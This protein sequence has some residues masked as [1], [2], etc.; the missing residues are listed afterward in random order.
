MPCI[1]VI[2]EDLEQR[3]AWRRLFVRAGYTV[4]DARDSREGLHYC[5]THVIDLVLMALLRPL[6]QE[7]AT[8]RAFRTGAPAVRLLVLV[9]RDVLGQMDGALLVSL[10]SVDRIF[11]HPVEETS[12]LAAVR[13][14]LAM[15]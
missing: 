13:A 9:A 11:E 8:L 1:L 12:V 6:A 10:S 15:P 4:M 2:T 5:Q 7:A 14:L 3:R